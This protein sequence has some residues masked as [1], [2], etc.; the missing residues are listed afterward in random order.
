MRR[1]LQLAMVRVAAVGARVR[2]DD[3]RRMPGRGGYLHRS[4]ECLAR[5]ER[6]KVKE[7]RSLRRKLGPVERQEL[8]ELIRSRLA[9]SAQLE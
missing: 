6:S 3:A 9:S 7:F 1:D 5:F 4:T 8:T 2:P